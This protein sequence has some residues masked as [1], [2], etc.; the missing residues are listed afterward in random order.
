MFILLQKICNSVITPEISVH[1]HAITMSSSA[2]HPLYNGSNNSRALHTIW[3]GFVLASIYVSSAPNS[4]HHLPSFSFQ[5]ALVHAAL[6]SFSSISMKVEGF[7]NSRPDL[8]EA[9]MS[10]K[11]ASF[12]S[13]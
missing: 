13:H 5:L 1:S 8:C 4:R 3:Y 12:S 9:K 11:T 2:V 10:L 7:P 6:I